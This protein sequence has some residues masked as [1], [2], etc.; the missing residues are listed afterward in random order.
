MKKIPYLFILC[1]LSLFG[2]KKEK[3]VSLTF[4]SPTAGA[5]IP[6]DSSFLVTVEIT[7]AIKADSIEYFLDTLKVAT[8]KL[9]NQEIGNLND[10]LLSTK[11]VSVGD[12]FLAIK[13]Y[14]KGKFEESATNITILPTTIPQKYSYKIKNTFPHDTSS[15][16]QGLEYHDGIFYE[17]DG[18]YGASS[19]R[20]VDVKTGKVIQKVDIDSQYFAEGL[21]VVDDK[22]ILLTWRERLGFVYDKKTLNKI[23]EFPYQNSAE[24]WGVCYDGRKLI[25]SDGT[26]RLYFLDKNTYL[27]TKSVDV[28]NNLG[29]IRLLNELE[30]IEGNIYA[31]VYETDIIVII[32]PITGVVEGEIDLSGLLPAKE[33]PTNNQNVLNGIA[34]DEKGKRLF[35]TGK[36]WNKLFEIEITPV[37]VLAGK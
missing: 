11:G 24:G 32:N 22:I 31:N 26:N 4:T 10:F 19:L 17:S 21:T 33:K 3:P 23:S 6:T 5:L 18:E 9:P 15:Y 12:H 27:E 20:K 36:K 29:P 35:V 13:V 37:S 16:T 30:Y 28:F 25:K 7:P 34:W 14:V 1:L 8:A 2:C